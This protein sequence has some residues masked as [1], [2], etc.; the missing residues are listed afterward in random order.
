MGWNKGLNSDYLGLYYNY[1]KLR[2]LS[3]R[4][5]YTQTTIS[6]RN[7]ELDNF[8]DIELMHGWMYKEKLLYLICSAGLSILHYQNTRHQLPNP[9]TGEVTNNYILPAIPF[10]LK[11]MFIPLP[12]LSIGGGFSGDFN[13]KQNYSAYFIEVGLGNFR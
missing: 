4:Y 11:A 2:F 6:F 12:Y 7:G 5:D 3:L 1:N 9:V 13:I 8:N 10:E